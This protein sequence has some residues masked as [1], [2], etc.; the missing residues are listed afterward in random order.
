M[1]NKASSA[2]QTGGRL[3]RCSTLTWQLNQFTLPDQQALNQA[4]LVDK[5]TKN[6]GFGMG[7]E[8]RESTNVL[9]TGSE[10]PVRAGMIFNV[11]VGECGV[12]LLRHAKIWLLA[13]Q[14][15]RSAK[16]VSPIS[17]QPWF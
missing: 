11:S 2:V 15:S 9:S 6:I 5:L 13:S 12:R 10:V 1:N 7:L 4:H 3:R 8:F 14:R 17:V 16:G